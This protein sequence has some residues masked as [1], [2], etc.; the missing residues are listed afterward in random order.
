[1][2]VSSF[3]RWFWLFAC[4]GWGATSNL[5]VGQQIVVDSAAS[6]LEAVIVEKYFSAMNSKE[7]PV[8]YPR[9]GVS[10]RIYVDLRE[11]YTLQAVFGNEQHELRIESSAPF[12]NVL[13]GGA[14][15]G[16]KVDERMFSTSAAAFDSWISMGAAS[17]VHSAVL[18]AEDA[19]GSILNYDGLNITDGLKK[20]F[21]AGT[22]YYG[23]APTA[24]DAVYGNESVFKTNNGSWANYV[25]VRGADKKR[26]QILIA[27]LTTT[28][29]LHFC[30]NIQ[31]ADLHGKK[32]QFVAKN[33]SEKQ[34][35]FSGL[36]QTIIAGQ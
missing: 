36:E 19:D 15:V 6:A 7:I 4:L 9:D 10:Y 31:I 29:S 33:P 21:V 17:R 32:I 35:A 3:K 30:L 16:N 23:I 27:Q 24:F 12:F 5:V 18:K 28:G 11:G 14:E 2:I 34:F 13:K 20:D 25:G 26:N 8:G 1:M 22:V